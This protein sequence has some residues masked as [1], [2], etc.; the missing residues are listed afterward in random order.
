MSLRRGFGFF[1]PQAINS[2]RFFGASAPVQLISQLRKDTGAS[3]QKCKEALET[4]G[5]DVNLAIQ[6][7]RK[8]GEGINATQF[9]KLD[10]SN[11][12]RIAATVSEDQRSAVIAKTVTQTDFAAESELFVK[13]TEAVTLGLCRF[14]DVPLDRLQIRDRFSSQIHSENLKD[15][16]S[17]ISSVLCEPVEVRSVESIKGDLVTVYVHNRSSYSDKVGASASAVAFSVTG[18]D[19]GQVKSISKLGGLI[20]RQVLAMSPKYVSESDIP[21]CVL[22]NEKEVLRSRVSDPTKLEKAFH[23]HMK[24]FV[25][26]NCLTNMEW[27]I[28]TTNPDSDGKTVRDIMRHECESL[29]IPHDAV[30]IDRFVIAKC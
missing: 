27:I 3:I 23:G 2:Q 25:S 11:S 6:L 17:E 20:A 9:G 8:R 10:S 7:L 22:E 5:N 15:I 12:M 13:F 28:P 4:S 24:R 18:L 16:T 29:G 21:S 1:V 14:P 19:S 30:R 26:E